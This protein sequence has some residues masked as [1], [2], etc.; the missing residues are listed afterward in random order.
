MAAS[1]FNSATLPSVRAA[2][3]QGSS[4]DREFTPADV[5]HRL[6]TGAAPSGN[7]HFSFTLSF[8]LTCH[9]DCEFNFIL[10]CRKQFILFSLRFV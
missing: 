8:L 1:M 7:L 4:R 6:A 2:A 10:E 3:S 5:S 9:C